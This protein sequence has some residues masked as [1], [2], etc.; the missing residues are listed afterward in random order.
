MTLV[1]V[2]SEEVIVLV[3]LTARFLSFFPDSGSP[4]C[5]TGDNERGIIGR[6]E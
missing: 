4:R 6:K 3:L 2:H 5:N 1:L